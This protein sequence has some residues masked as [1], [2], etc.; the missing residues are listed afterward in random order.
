V[1]PNLGKCRFCGRILTSEEIKEHMVTRHGREY[2]KL[3]KEA[4]NEVL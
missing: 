4:F 2:A 3:L 1:I